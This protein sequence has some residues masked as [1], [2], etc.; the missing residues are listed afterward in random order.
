MIRHETLSWLA[1]GDKPE[2][3]IPTDPAKRARGLELYEQAGEMLGVEK[4]VAEPTTTSIPSGVSSHPDSG[5]TKIDLDAMYVAVESAAR[6]GMENANVRID[7]NDREA[8]RIM[9]DMV[10]QF[11]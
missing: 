3:V 7:W 6:R 4:A 2:V 11:A 8:G 9:R 5:T 1:E 10:V